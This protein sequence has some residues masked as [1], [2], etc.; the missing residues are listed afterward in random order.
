[1]AKQATTDDLR[2]EE[3][4]DGVESARVLIVGTGFAGLGTALRL[5]QRGDHDFIVLERAQSVGGTWRDNTYPGCACDVPSNLYSFSFAPNPDWSSSYS[6]QPEI[7]A[8]LERCAAD[9]GV[10]P[11]VRFGRQATAAH[12]DEARRRWVVT[13]TDGTFEGRYLVAGMGPLSEPSVPDIAGIDTFEGATFHSATWDHDHD[14]AGE[15]VAVIGTGA[16]SIQL[17]P[18]IQPEVARLDLYQRTPP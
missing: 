11:H 14:L 15:R 8:Y 2:D 17:V 12:W 7:R 3:R 16:S 1:M 18:A 4:T 10:L 6:P 13:T 9:G 5:K